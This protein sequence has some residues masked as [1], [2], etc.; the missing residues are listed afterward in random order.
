MALLLPLAAGLSAQNLDPTVRVVRD[1]N[2]QLRAGEKQDI[3]VFLPDSVLHFNAK[4]DYEVFAQ[5]YR[6]AYEFSP[7]LLELTPEPARWTGKTFYLRAGAGYTLRPELTAAYSPNL[8]NPDWLLGVWVNHH[9]HI[10]SYRGQMGGADF[11]GY[12]LQSS[13]RV[14]ARKLFKKHYIDFSAAYQGLHARHDG[15]FDRNYNLGRLKLQGGKQAYGEFIYDVA[16]S[17]DFGGDYLLGPACTALG[18]GDKHLMTVD[19][20]LKATVGSLA[21]RS[22]GFLLDVDVLASGMKD[23]IGLGDVLF[24]ATPRYLFR[25]KDFSL[26]LGLSLGLLPKFGGDAG[27]QRARTQVV[28]P[29]IRIGFDALQDYLKIYLNLTGGNSLQTYLSHSLQNRFF[30]PLYGAYSTCV[31]DYTVERL[32]LALG[33]QGRVTRKFS[34]DAAVGWKT[35]QNAPLWGV[36]TVDGKAL[37]QLVYEGWNGLYADLKLNLELESVTVDA[38]LHYQGSNVMRDLRDVFEPA[39]FTADLR[40]RYNWNR[41]IWAGLFL[42]AASDSQGYLYHVETASAEESVLKGWV[43][44]GLDVEFR[45]SQS[46]ALWL[47]A[48]NLLNQ[49]IN[50]N[51]MYAERGVWAQVGLTLNF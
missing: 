44:L 14:D 29:N 46:L 32:N 41:R 39:P 21:S 1:Y 15:Q 9:S 5:P 37:P 50:R 25:W 3:P 40:A 35:Y 7:Y 34:Y 28:Y 22:Q 23:M 18:W 24:T 20:G 19:A 51:L 13:V 27:R 8:A 10:G 26:D 4:Y 11:G 42:Q 49:T 17:L 31:P 33:L 2:A 30:T 36:W 38:R 16:L 6:G 48:G 12:D 47:R 43:D 45:F